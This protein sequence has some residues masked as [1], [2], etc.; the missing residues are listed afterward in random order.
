MPLG[1]SKSVHFTV[2]ASNDAHIGFFAEPGGSWSGEGHEHYEIVLSGWGNTQS[3]IREAS[4]G[5]NHEVTETTGFLSL[6][7]TRAFWASA[8]RGS[9]ALA[10]RLGSL[11]LADVALRSQVARSSLGRDR[12]SAGTSS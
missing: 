2:S 12:M 3:V 8:F 1:P 11:L 9:L 4:Q 10:F 5:Q 6:E 7:E